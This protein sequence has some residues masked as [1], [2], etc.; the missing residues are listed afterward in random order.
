MNKNGDG[1]SAGRNFEV[2]FNLA[3]QPNFL[4][5][6]NCTNKAQELQLRNILAYCVAFIDQL[7]PR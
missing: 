3:I 2:A 5:E 6:G 4:A 1:T 7:E